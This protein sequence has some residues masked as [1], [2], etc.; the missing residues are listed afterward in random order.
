MGWDVHWF[1]NAVTPLVVAYC[2]RPRI[3]PTYLDTYLVLSV[4]GTVTVRYRI[5]SFVI[6]EPNECVLSIVG[7]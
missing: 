7:S 4:V 1:Y 6:E 2:R 3:V 5:F